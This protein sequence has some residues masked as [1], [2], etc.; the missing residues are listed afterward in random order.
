ME[1]AAPRL[2]LPPTPPPMPSPPQV[3]VP[4]PFS[5]HLDIE[6]L[7]KDKHRLE[8]EVVV[9]K[10]E[11]NRL[12]KLI[13]ERRAVHIDMLMFELINRGVGERK[14]TIKSH[15]ETLVLLRQMDAQYAQ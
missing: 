3:L 11:Y 2:P 15:K 6:W 14:R 13:S 10:L 8:R 5:P 12:Y 9:L 4:Q 7:T 1:G